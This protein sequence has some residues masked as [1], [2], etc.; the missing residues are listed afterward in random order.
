MVVKR[1]ELSPR[2]MQ[3]IKRG[4]YPVQVVRRLGA[5]A[6]LVSEKGLSEAKKIPGYHDEPLQGREYTTVRMH[7]IR[8]SLQWRAF[9]FVTTNGDVMCAY[10]EKVTAHVY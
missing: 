7:S 10:V 4:K 8:L 6:R 1:V 2:V 3:D 5:W 9:Y